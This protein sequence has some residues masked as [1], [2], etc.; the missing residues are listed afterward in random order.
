MYGKINELNK[1]LENKSE[2]EQLQI[3]SSEFSGEIVFSTSFQFEDQII[4]D[5]IFS[6]DLPIEVFT[7]DTGRHFEETYKTL[8]KTTDFYKKQIKVYFPEYEQVEKLINEKGA[9]SFYESVENRIECCH[10][11]KVVPLERALQGK[12]CWV[13]GLR[14]EQSNARTEVQLLEWDEKHELIKF[15]P[16]I[17]RT[18]EQ[19][20][21][22]IQKNNVPYNI[23]QDKGF[24]S[25]GCAPC[26]RAIQAGEP[27]RAGRWWWEDNSKK[28]CGLHVK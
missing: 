16:L 10:I 21:E 9:F 5:M 3:L 23:L 12:K 11:R 20:K 26:T 6:N 1:L 14:R 22:Y 28:E 19:V 18:F 4:T 17:N 13:T 25:I 15:N 24:P 7:L 2:V 8:N 27:I